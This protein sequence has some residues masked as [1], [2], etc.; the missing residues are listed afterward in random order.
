MTCLLFSF[1][2]K[3]TKLVYET[4]IQNSTWKT[5]KEITKIFYDSHGLPSSLWS[6]R[7]TN[8]FPL[9]QIFLSKRVR[10]IHSGMHSPRTFRHK[11]SKIGKG[12]HFFFLRCS[13]HTN[14]EP[15]V[16]DRVGILRLT[17]YC[18]TSPTEDRMNPIQAQKKGSKGQT[19]ITCELKKNE[20]EVWPWSIRDLQEGRQPG[21]HLR[22]KDKWGYSRNYKVSLKLF[23]WSMR[24]LK[25]IS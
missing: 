8:P 17:L 10:I 23:S 20:S 22:Q 11:T 1:V 6:V 21:R 9:L 5:G 4:R 13:F 24:L 14:Y 3:H 2:K 16:L 7:K 18:L 12:R 15:K 25:K 19:V